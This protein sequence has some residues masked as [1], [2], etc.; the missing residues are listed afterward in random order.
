[1]Q[2]S[3]GIVRSTLPVSMTPKLDDYAN[4]L[5]L[6]HEWFSRANDDFKCLAVMMQWQENFSPTIDE[7]L[8]IV[9]SLPTL[10]ESEA[11]NGNW[12]DVAIR[13]RVKQQIASVLLD[14]SEAQ[15]LRQDLE[16][17]FSHRAFLSA[18]R[19]LIEKG[20]RYLSWWNRLVGGYAK[21]RTEIADLYKSAVP[22]TKILL[23]DILQLA[24]FHKRMIEVENVYEELKDTL[25]TG[26][27]VDN[28]DSWKK[29]LDSLNAFE[30][31]ISAAPQVVSAMPT[32]SV[33]I[34][35]RPNDPLL[36]QLAEHLHRGSTDDA[37]NSFSSLR[38]VNMR[39][40]DGLI[41]I[42]SLQTALQCCIAAIQAAAT[43]YK[44]APSME[45]LL[46]DLALARVYADQRNT[47]AS[48]FAKHSHDLPLDA[49]P[50][51]PDG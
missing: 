41:T 12:A 40:N 32:R 20:K 1:L 49:E 35:I 50:F 9:K 47:V 21:Y 33:A 14:L 13:G 43:K 42:S 36:A 5:N 23:D 51:K 27:I 4:Y 6:E 10:L 37:S 3:W 18:S 31:F 16:T 7:A 48:L 28:T 17:R 45:L 46:G 15:E 30:A 34:N 8:T 24:T 22:E 19:S 29:T 44:T 38:I 39:I 2:R 26:L 11:Y 25:L